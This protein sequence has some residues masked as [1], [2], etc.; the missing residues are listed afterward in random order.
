MANQKFVTILCIFLFGAVALAQVTTGTISGTV[1]DST[2]AVLPGAQVVLLN[3]ETGGSRTIQSD[4]AG[5]YTA[6]ALSLGRYRVTA[7]LEGFQTVVRSGITLTVGQDAVV[8]LTLSVGAVAEKV[9]VVGEAPMVETTNA[10]VSGLVNQEQ[11]RD[12]PLNGRS[13]TDLALL[14]AGVLY[15]RTT[16]SDPS[17]G[18][19]PRLSVNGARADAN[20]YLIDGTVASKNSGDTG[21]VATVSLGVEGIR[22]FRVLTHNFSAEYGQNAGAVLSMVTRSGTNQLHGSAYEFVR[23][24]IFDAR[25]F[26]NVGAL[27]EFRRNQFGAAAGGP[28]K[29]D[30]IFFFANYEGLRQRQGNSLVATVPDANARLG[31]LPCKVITPAPNPCPASGVAPLPGF[32]PAVAPYFILWPLPNIRNFGDGTGL[33]ST[34]FVQPATE[35]Y[36]L[37]RM[38]FHLSDKDNFYWRY[39][40]DP[41]SDNRPQAVSYFSTPDDGVSH[42]LV[43]SETHI[44]SPNA[45]NDFHFSFNRSALSAVDA[46]TLPQINEGSFPFIPGFPFGDIRFSTASLG[47]AGGTLAAVGNARN[48]PFA[49]LQNLFEE[50]DTF[51]LIRGPHSMKFGLSVQRDDENTL[52]GQNW[53]GDWVIASLQSFMTGSAT[54]YNG[55]NLAASTRGRGFRRTFLGWFAQDDYRVSSRL[56]LNLG[57]R[58]E[59]YTAPTEA[60]GRSGDLINLTDPVST[61]GPAFL[62]GKKNFAP[63]V[64][65]AWDPT[66]SGKTAIRAGFGVYFNQVDGRTWNRLTD[67]EVLF[68]QGYTVR[69]PTTFPVPPAAPAGGFVGA[70]A[71]VQYHLP[72]PTVLQA[73]FDIQRQLTSAMSLRLGFV[74]SHGDNMT[75]I[76]FPDIRVPTILADGSKSY[77]STSPFVNPN[78]S[79]FEQLRA[80]VTSN[81]DAFQA[82]LQKSTGHG[83]MFQVAYSYSKALSVSDASANRSVD[84]AGPYNTMDWLNPNRD[85]GPSAYDQRHTFTLNSQYILPFD[86]FLKN[87]MEKA[88]LG[89]WEING[90]YTYGSGMP[91][92]VTDG[93]NRSGNG[94]TNNPDRPNLTPG[95]SANPTSGVTAGCSAGGVVI[96]AGQPLH[97]PN[98]WYDPCAFSLPAP[99]LYGNLGRDTLHGPNFNQ[100]NFT[101]VKHTAITERK[102]LEFRAEFFNFFN[103]PSFGLPSLTAFTNTG[104]YSGNAGTILSTTSRGRQIQLGLKFTF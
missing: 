71:G 103:H 22:E 35:D 34:N 44:F 12:L 65:V 54:Q 78:F 99:G 13:F 50:A 81:Y 3:E 85:Y 57:F 61:Q 92:N 39:I 10:T 79:T 62:P 53:A 94:D 104:A 97:T 8:E 31:L 55:A 32:K 9:E 28:L 19:A 100:V 21:S 20:L 58:H 43:L 23:N 86:N 69:N 36:T 59:F 83:L 66:G 24:D 51:N 72:T 96:P 40:Y 45:L 82:A 1:K 16:G 56:T 47:S 102:Q 6:S 68:F 30:S 98:R 101:L 90:I 63:R 49:F 77:A 88:L 73:S 18:F 80:D 70:E 4:A 75:R 26:F 84:N 76:V 64:G 15:N 91:L 74:S 11:M 41:S 87:G 25:D 17:T 33:N 42:F 48:E 7:T 60:H 89:G 67:S 27:P 14:S 95:F 5:R 2:G 46:T 52:Y 37:T 93:F 38:D 29:K